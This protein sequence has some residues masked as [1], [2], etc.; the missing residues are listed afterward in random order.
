MRTFT[1]TVTFTVGPDSDEH[2]RD[3]QAIEDEMRSWLESLKAT[4]VE[5]EVKR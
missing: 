2:L 1:L 5:L 4:V 3:E